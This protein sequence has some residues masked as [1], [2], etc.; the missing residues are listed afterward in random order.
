GDERARMRDADPE[1]EIGDVDGPQDGRLIAG[2]SE[3]HIHLMP[4]REERQ[5]KDHQ[6][7]GHAGEIGDARRLET[8]KDVVVDAAEAHVLLTPPPGGTT[9]FFRYVMA[10][11]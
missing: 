4:E 7:Q 3:P 5:R 2:D 11:R 9:T 10:G 1:D 8:A 6:R